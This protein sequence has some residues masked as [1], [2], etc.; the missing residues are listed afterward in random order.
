[1]IVKNISQRQKYSVNYISDSKAM[2]LNNEIIDKYCNILGQKKYSGKQTKRNSYMK[3]TYD[4]GILEDSNN[5][6]KTQRLSSNLSSKWM[7]NGKNMG[8]EGNANGCKSAGR[9]HSK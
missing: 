7:L 9:N 5:F 8:D 1:M 6:S 2:T 3:S 4:R